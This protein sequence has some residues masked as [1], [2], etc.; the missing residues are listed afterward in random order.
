MKR[1]IAWRN[2]CEAHYERTAHP[3]WR[4]ELVKALTEQILA[5]AAEDARLDKRHQRA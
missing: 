2:Y 5:L 4:R 3:Y 1:I